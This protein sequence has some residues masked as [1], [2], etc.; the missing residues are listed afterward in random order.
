MHSALRKDIFMKRLIA[1]ILSVLLL[2]AFWSGCTQSGT[3]TPEGT[4]LPTSSPI[5]TLDPSPEE[6]PD[7]EPTP[8]EKDNFSN[9]KPVYSTVRDESGMWDDVITFN[10]FN[11]DDYE[12]RWSEYSKQ[13]MLESFHIKVGYIIPPINGFESTWQVSSNKL[14]DDPV[15][16][17]DYRVKLVSLFLSEATRPDYLPAVYASCIGSD[18]A[19]FSLEEYLVDLAPYLEEGGSLYD[20]YVR[21]LWGDNVE[22]WEEMKTALVTNLGQLFVIP[23]REIMPVQKYLG[24]SFTALDMLGIEWDDK[25]TDWDGFYE[26]LLQ[27]K[28]L[29]EEMCLEGE[30]YNGVSFRTYEENGADLIEFIATTY[31]LDFNADFSWT[32]KNGEPL[33][34]YYWDEYLEILKKV[35]TLA[36]NELVL[37]NINEKGYIANYTLDRSDISYLESVRSQEDTGMF[38]GIA[39]YATAEWFSAHST[40][41]GDGNVWQVSDTWI[42]QDGCTYSL[43]GGSEFDS[44]YLAIGNA[45]GNEFV[46]RIID[47]WNASLSDEGYLRYQ[48]GQ[49]GIPFADTIEEAG[50]YLFDEEGNVVFS[51]HSNLIPFEKN[52]DY[53]WWRTRNEDWWYSRSG[54]YYQYIS[55]MNSSLYSSIMAGDGTTLADYLGINKTLVWENDS[56]QFRC[57]T[58]FYADVTAYPNRKTAYWPMESM[59]RYEQNIKTVLSEAKENNSVCYKGF[60][61]STRELLGKDSGDMT[62]KINHLQSLAMDFTLKFLSD[63]ANEAGWVNYIRSIQEAGYQDVYDFYCRALYG[64]VTDY[65][66]DVLSQ[67]K[68]N[69]IQE[70]K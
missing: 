22:Y 61:K 49:K 51:N 5:A 29:R 11:T 64:C 33:W 38:S 70:S 66:E 56:S 55:K 10:V 30:E 59:A 16:R 60:Y 43:T 32:T 3:A 23:R 69:M 40:N 41:Y 63:E 65:R 7:V 4:L 48:F 57:G 44:N 62:R 53:E 34:T 46:N 68:T 54:Y 13:W 12:T 14:M 20:G 8:E 50:N 35:K 45:L 25:P 15:A 28:T 31:G 58:W 21:W 24:Y 18:G 47:F 52:D 26:M 67:S 17:D 36:A 27:Y 6:S 1:L 39:A 37:T 19:W 9:A 2:T 42:S